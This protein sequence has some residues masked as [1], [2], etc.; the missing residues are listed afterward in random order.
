MWLHRKCSKW[1]DY[2]SAKLLP[3]WSLVLTGLKSHHP[4]SLHHFFWLIMDCKVR[5]G[6]ALELDEQWIHCHS[7]AD[8]LTICVDQPHHL[9]LVEFDVLYNRVDSEIVSLGLLK[10][11]HTPILE[12]LVNVSFT[13][14]VGVCITGHWATVI[15]V[16]VWG[17]SHCCWD[18]EWV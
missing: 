18:N 2:L 14:M 1:L 11:N 3:L 16:L 12:L 5:F 7:F 13:V 6:W 17:E 4:M 8:W 9:V 15:L 10:V